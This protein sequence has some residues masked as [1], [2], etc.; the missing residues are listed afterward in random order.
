MLILQGFL[1][2]NYGS[3]VLFSNQRLIECIGKQFMP[4]LQVGNR[5]LVLFLGQIK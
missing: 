4:S 5:N 2:K 1:L 3:P